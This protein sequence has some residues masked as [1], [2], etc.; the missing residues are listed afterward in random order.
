MTKEAPKEKKNDAFMRPV[1]VSDALAE[2][3]GRG[4]M[5][6][7]E[8]TKRVWV[9]IKSHKLQDAKDRRKINPDAKLARVLGT[10]DG[11]DMFKMTK[12]ISTH[13]RQPQKAHA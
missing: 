2:I 3:V 6:R 13:I 7:T 10:H 4:P 5:P 11:I 12:K 9:Y 8:I 1:E